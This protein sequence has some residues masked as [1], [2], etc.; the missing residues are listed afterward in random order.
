MNELGSGI[1]GSPYMGDGTLA[2]KLDRAR[3]ELLDLSARNRL[4]NMPKSAKSAKSIEIIDERSTEIF[5]LLVNEGKAFTFLPGLPSRKSAQASEGEDVRGDEEDTDVIL[6]LALPE[7]DEMDDRGVAGRHADTR[8]QTRFTPEGLQKRL[9]DLYYDARTLEDE[10]G[11]NVLYL[12][13]GA[14]RWVDPNDKKNIRHA[15]LL[16]IPVSLERGTAGERFR[17]RARPEDFATNLSLE[18]FLDRLHGIRLPEPEISEAFDLA[19]YFD[20]VGQSLDGKEG[21]G[22]EPDTVVLGFF[23]FAKFMMYRDLDPATWPEEASITS[24]PLLRGLLADGFEASEALHPDDQPIDKIIPPADL[25]HILDSDSSQTLAVHEV[26]RGRNLVIQGPPGTGK[27]QT[28]ANLIAAAVADGKTV[29]FVAE[30]MA[31]LEVVKRRLD[32][33]GVGAACLELHSHKA[34][35]KAV[36]EEIKRTWE[37]G[38]PRTA[39]IGSLNARLGELRD[40]LNEHAERMHRR[41]SISGLSPYQ[42]VGQLVRLRAAGEQPNDLALGQPGE[43]T[44]EGFEN[45]HAILRELVERVQQIGNPSQHIWYGVELASVTPM[46]VERLAARLAALASDGEALRDSGT[47]LAKLLHADEPATGKQLEPL[48]GLA[49]RILAAPLGR[50]ALASGVWSDPPSLEAV[51]RNGELME[52]ARKLLAGQVEDAAWQDQALGVR[53]PLEA[54]PADSNAKD[55]EILAALS[56]ELPILLEAADDLARQMNEPAPETLYQVSA[57]VRLAKRVASAPVAQGAALADPVW[58]QNPAGPAELVSAVKVYQ[59]ARAEL[60]G[61][62]A[63]AAWDTDLAP[64]RAVLAAHGT[65]LFKALSGEWRRANRLVQSC[66]VNPSQPLEASLAQLDR[67]RQG[68]AARA[69]IVRDDA[70]GRSAFGGL[71]RGDRSDVGQLSSIVAWQAS[72]G[73]TARQVR[74]VAEGEPDREQISRHLGRLA[75]LSGVSQS[76]DHLAALW[77]EGA[78]APARDILRRAVELTDA[79]QATRVLFR[80]LPST[81]GERLRLLDRLGQGQHAAG[82]VDAGSDLAAAAFG[83]LW[84]GTGSDWRSLKFAAKW[85]AENGDIL[86]TAGRVEER[87]E[88][89]RLADEVEARSTTFAADILRLAGDLQL[90]I[91]KSL[92]G[93]LDD[94]ALEVLLTRLHDWGVAGESLFQW[95]AYRDRAQQGRRLGCADVVDR[96]ESGGLAPDAVISAFEMA[97]YEALHSGLVASNPELGRF[98]GTLH[99]RKVAEFAE[100]DLQR[101]RVSADETVRAHYRRVPPRDGGAIGPLGVLRTELQKRRG[102][103]PIRKLVER[104]GP[105]LQA[106]KPV[107]MMSPLSVAQFLA[108]GAVEFDLLVMDEASQIQPV[109]ALGAVARARQVVVVGDPR[110][111]PPTA[112]FARMTG[113]SDGDED[114]GGRVT[115]IE[116]ILGLFTARGLPMRMLRWHY[117]SRHQSLIAVSNRQFYESKLFVVPSPY[118]AEA[119]MGLRFHHIPDGLFDAGGKRCNHIEAKAVARAIIEHAITC[120]DLSLGVAAFSVAQRR[121]ILD[122]LELLRRANPETE[123]FFQA[124]AAEPF[125]VKNLENVQGDERDVILISVGYGPTV[126]G[127]R[128]PMRFGPLGSEGGER[129]LNVL[130]SRA[131]QRCEVFASMTDEDIDPDFAQSRKGVFAFRLFLHFARTGS[132]AMGEATGRDHDSVFE[133]QV[134]RALHDQGYHVHR[135]VG[136]AG[137]FIDL[138]V[139]DPERPGRYLLGIECDGAAYHDALS[140]RDRDRLRQSVLESHGW[141]IHRIWSTDWFQRPQQELARVIEAIDAAK[142]EDAARETTRQKPIV[143]ITSLEMGDHTLMGI[144]AGDVGEVTESGV[145]MPCF[146]EEADIHRAAVHM[147]DLHL[148][149]SPLLAIYVEQVVDIEG[150]VHFDEIVTRIR[151][152]W[153]LKKA[154]QRI[155]DAISAALSISVRK[156]AVICSDNAVHKYGFVTIPSRAPKF[157][158]RS[159][160]SSS[161][162]RKPEYLPLDE[163]AVGAIALVEKNFGATVDQLVT[164]IARCLG[165]KATSDVLRGRIVG[166]IEVAQR[167]GR[168]MEHG[169]LLQSVSRGS[170]V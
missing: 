65:G 155:R 110:Q 119:G 150:P 157:R 133:E 153:G 104:A 80:H 138:A 51:L 106:L 99:S 79:E 52:D 136:L 55:F 162:L 47:R 148:L 149:P 111:L 62:L 156:G 115:D 139:S 140:A 131:K 142:A 19:G 87:E 21:W 160:V 169:G 165:F 116:S 70:V 120:P 9:L 69:E 161:G 44:R 105:A 6:D 46:E 39:D 147:M 95:T 5:R 163:I 11:V 167:D 125:F 75:N 102:H 40:E 76:A 143:R 121:A 154:G 73:D 50:E 25:H 130:I 122:E 128:V 166:G 109:D 124:H 8:L 12:T 113:N 93:D 54:L 108:P 64:A 23:S 114:D 134:A 118:T 85:V 32:A 81:L 14:L 24:R 3:M 164:E 38:A 146:Y 37:N 53:K 78:Q 58:E 89:G 107:F 72:L 2:D 27:S 31:A 170:D 48:I 90:D 98:D 141:H 135:Q 96:L 117:R 101:I 112:F 18:N 100:F 17:L 43:W 41:D 168:L 28:I 34:N 10:Q 42:V 15:P 22:V 60:D 103:M 35:K 132:L 151:E 91:A 1:E 158:D 66:L 82:L 129:R 144:E 94:V 29:L 145:F 86:D 59:D 88:A 83:P 67:L 45:R 77:P 33:T 123:G 61:A 97:Y 71:W 7:D 30:K 4:L 26:R 16:L 137:F 127:G 74:R 68:K 56:R 63:E 20:V 152:A 49:R 13:L 92:G 36:L 57:L 84:A 159:Q 126:P